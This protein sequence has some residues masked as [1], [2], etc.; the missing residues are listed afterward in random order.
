MSLENRRMRT[1]FT[2]VED[3]FLRENIHDCHTIYD[4]T[5]EFNAAF[6]HHQTT[7]SNLRHRLVIL[8][9]RKGTHNIRKEK[10]HSRNDIGTIIASKDGKKARVKTEYG[11]VS[12]H[13]YFLE[14]YFDKPGVSYLE[15]ALVHLNGDLTDFTRDNVECVSRSVYSSM[16]SRKWFFHDPELTKT[17]ILTATLLE[18]FPDLR[19]NE[20]QYLKR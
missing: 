5:V 19:H 13:K 4:L 8:G 14:K 7:D 17:A 3:D 15:Y 16:Q 2:Q 11:Y 20:D 12:A 10:I 9:L 6:P 18:F 1:K